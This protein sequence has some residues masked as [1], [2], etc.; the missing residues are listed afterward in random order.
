MYLCIIHIISKNIVQYIP[1]RVVIVI[2]FYKSK[3]YTLYTLKPVCPLFWRFQPFKRR[4]KLPT[5]TTRLLPLIRG[6]EGPITIRTV[7]TLPHLL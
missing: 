4:T 6:D 3:L 7:C 2:P 1:Y 5:K